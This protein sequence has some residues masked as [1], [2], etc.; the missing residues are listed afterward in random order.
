[1]VSNRRIIDITG[2][3]FYPTPEWATRALLSK[4]TFNGRLL[5][6]CCGDGAMAEVLTEAGYVVEA[7]DIIDRGYG[8]ICDFMDIKGPRDNI[9]T[10]PPFKIAAKLLDHA[11][12]IAKK[13]VCFLL[14]TAFLESQT[15]YFTFYKDRPP[16]NVLVFSE[17]LSMYPKGYTVRGGGTTSY[18]WFVW[19]NDDSSGETKIKWIEPGFKSKPM[20]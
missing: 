5:E 16:S 6:P 2:P 13:K 20:K 12:N 1:M 18:S 7:S 8:S 15:R 17:R 10:N 9:I 4:V 3:D 19:D 11:L 14:R